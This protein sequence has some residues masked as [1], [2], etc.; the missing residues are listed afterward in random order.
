VAKI[1]EK[2]WK[3]EGYFVFYSAGNGILDQCHDFDKKIAAD[4]K[5]RVTRVIF[6]Q[7][8]LTQLIY[9]G[10]TRVKR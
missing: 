1:G 8:L 6:P 5:I 3:T 7:A 9:C 4:L 2:L 10:Q